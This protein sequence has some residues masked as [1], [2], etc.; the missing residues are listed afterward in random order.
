MQVRNIALL[1]HKDHGKS[2]LIGRLLMQ[3]GAATRVRIREAQ[4][5]SR[6]L[7]RGFEPAFILDSFTE[8]RLNEMTYDTT[9]AEIKHRGMAL[10]FIDVPGHEELIKNMI[11][12]ASYGE[13]AVL[14][15][16]AKPD[17]GIR[18]QTKRHLFVAR[19][20]GIDR[21][22]VAVNKMDTVNYDEERFRAIERG[23]R[24]FISA[25]GFDERNVAFVP[26]SAYDGEN[27]VKRS[28]RMRWYGGKPLVEMIYESAKK[29]TPKATGMLRI[30][31]QG[32]LPGGLVAGKIVSGSVRAGEMVAILPKGAAVKVR[33]ITVKGA[34]VKVGNA[35]N[36]VALALA[37]TLPKEM[38]GTII[39]GMSSRPIVTGMI[40]LRVF[41][42]GAFGR[43]MS[44]KF[45]G[46]DIPCRKVRVLRVIDTTT[47]ALRPGPPRLLD[48]VEADIT[49]S[50]KVPVEGYA[51]TPELGRF[52]LYNKGMFAGIGI[53]EPE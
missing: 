4:E 18:G 12:G 27:T 1:G 41:V 9:R 22:I 52:V 5:Y 21:L 8:E 38:R 35:G 44:V 37:G 19:M 13:V 34:V 47:G 24:G 6:R 45:N 49:L 16:S 15:V 11:S 7:G 33:N 53:I 30:A 25:I 31:V 17:E 40:R 23:L 26:I 50:R 42:T 29:A 32:T 3:T 46:I 28:A 36:N 39:S 20:L 10:A 48:A 43:A 2:T 14:L 51:I